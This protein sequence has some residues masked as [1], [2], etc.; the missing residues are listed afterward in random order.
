MSIYAIGDLQGCLN[1]LQRLLDKIKFEPGADQLWFV[2]DLVNRGPK[3]LDTLRFVKSLGESAITVLGNHDFH[4]LAMAAGNMKYF[5]KSDSLDPILLAEDREELMNWLR[6]QK[7]MHTDKK[8]KV[9]LVHAGIHP[10]WS[11]KQAKKQARKIEHVLQSPQ[12]TKFLKNMYGNRP[13]LWHKLSR[14]QDQ[15]RFILNT[16][17]RMRYVYTNGKLDFKYNGD[18]GSQAKKLIPWFLHPNNKLKNNKVIFGH[19]SRLSIRQTNNVF[20]IDTGCL[21]GEH[22]SA[23]EINPQYYRWHSIRCH[24]KDL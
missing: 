17:T 21:W 19:W 2:G 20:A 14:E 1:S 6:Q 8:L 22:L 11:I 4:L 12:A 3:S 9:S 23:L 5:K 7:L 16:F 24:K 13:K 18:I 10:S 15:L